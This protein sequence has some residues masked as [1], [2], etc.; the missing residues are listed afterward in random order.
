MNDCSPIV[1]AEGTATPAGR[2]LLVEDEVFVVLDVQM[3]L[4]D[5]GIDQVATASTLEDALCAVERGPYALAILDLNLRGKESWP[6]A[7]R[8]AQAGVP[9]VFISAYPIGE[10]RLG[11]HGAM[12]VP[13]PFSPS[14]LASA[15]Q[16]VVQPAQ[17]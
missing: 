14:E 11:E 17:G 13:K 9:I 12:H 7:E 15:V 6:V 5:I 1:P 10:D 3:M 2:V 8:L 16:S 4:E